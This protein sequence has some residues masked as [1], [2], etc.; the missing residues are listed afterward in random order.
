MLDVGAELKSRLCPDACVARV[1]VAVAV[2][3][4]VADSV[5]EE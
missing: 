2:A 4:A 5:A 1:Y 3:V